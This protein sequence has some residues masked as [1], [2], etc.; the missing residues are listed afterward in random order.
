MRGVQKESVVTAF[1]M[2]GLFSRR[3]KR[4][5]KDKDR[6][7][8]VSINIIPDEPMIDDSMNVQDFD[9]RANADLSLNDLNGTVFTLG[10]TAATTDL[11]SYT[12]SPIA[13]PTMNAEVL[14][15]SSMSSQFVIPSGLSKG[16]H[17][18]TPK[19]EKFLTGGNRKTSSSARS[20]KSSSF[21]LSNASSGHHKERRSSR[22]KKGHRRSQSLMNAPVISS[23]HQQRRPKTNESN[24]TK[25]LKRIHLERYAAMFEREEIDMEAFKELCD[26]DLKDLGISDQSARLSIMEEIKK[27]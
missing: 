26:D 5:N 6:S 3:F 25:V 7:N 17:N 13:P 11:S 18:N 2:L 12:V 20:K 15:S 9:T 22:A 27:L 23:G 10:F 1:K 24:V 21:S 4:L 8:K 19:T 14:K 16:G